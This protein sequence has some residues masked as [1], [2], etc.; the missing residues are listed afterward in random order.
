[1]KVI[2]FLQHRNVPNGIMRVEFG[3]YIQHFILRGYGKARQEVKY[4]M[5]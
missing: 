5:K 4:R 1:M 3:E 2:L